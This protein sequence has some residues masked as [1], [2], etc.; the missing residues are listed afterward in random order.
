MSARVPITY[1]AATPDDWPGIRA[2]LQ[3]CE[4][5]LAGVEDPV[6]D[7]VVAAELAGVVGCV[8]IE[9]HGID[10]L[11]RSCAVAGQHRGQGIGIALTEQAIALAK[12]MGIRHLVLLT[13]TAENFFPRFGFSRIR[14]EQVPVS[15]RDAEEIR[16]ACPAKRGS[17]SGCKEICRLHRRRSI[18]RT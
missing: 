17:G 10:A 4:L 9:R 14:R 6:A 3:S 15:L 8:G 5:P 12:A 7:F 2:L 18:G 11:L 1:R 13:T 16:N